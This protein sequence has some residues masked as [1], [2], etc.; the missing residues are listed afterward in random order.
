MAKGFNEH[1]LPWTL[2]VLDLRR[3]Y[4]NT[5]NEPPSLTTDE[6]IN[7]TSDPR[8]GKLTR[9]RKHSKPAWYGLSQVAEEEELGLSGDI[10]QYRKQW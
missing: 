1:T 5:K 6:S 2:Y 4:S 9:L 3:W 7:R 10:R 8:V